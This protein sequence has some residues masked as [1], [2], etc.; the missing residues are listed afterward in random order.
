MDMRGLTEDVWEDALR[1]A[2]L[3]AKKIFRLLQDQEECASLC[4]SHLPGIWRRWDPS[5]GT[6]SNYMNISF[7]N[8]SRTCWRIG[9]RHRHPVPGRTMVT[10][11]WDSGWDDDEEEN[12][13]ENF[14]RIVRPDGKDRQEDARD[15]ID[16]VHRLSSW[17]RFTD[18]EKKEFVLFM[19]GD[20][21]TSHDKRRDNAR[22]RM[23]AKLRWFLKLNW[24]KD[25]KD[26][27]VAAQYQTRAQCGHVYKRRQ[28][29]CTKCGAKF[30]VTNS[31][32]SSRE[33]CWDCKPKG[34]LQSQRKPKRRQKWQD[35][36]CEKCGAT[37]SIHSSSSLYRTLCWTCQPAQ[38]TGMTT[39][40]CSEC[41]KEFQRR[42]YLVRR[43]RCWDCK[44][45]FGR[46]KT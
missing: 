26:L 3:A 16:E 24:G 27:A 2:K 33:E 8:L 23:L 18:V 15:G 37:F 14:L 11:D 40:T 41:G 39:A 25:D 20:H 42:N 10:L 1:V 28:R 17:I 22:Q 19:Q 9:E 35:K 21:S 5:L 12:E 38:G 32:T 4:M 13:P 7:T 43:T 34:R 31:Y 44:P 30:T 29:T 6:W 45:R 36:I 46:K